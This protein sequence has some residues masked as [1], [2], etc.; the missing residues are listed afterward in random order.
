MFPAESYPN[1][2]PLEK[3]FWIISKKNP[4]SLLNSSFQ[5]QWAGGGGNFFLELLLPFECCS[6]RGHDIRIYTVRIK[7]SASLWAARRSF[8]RVRVPLNFRTNFSCYVTRS[9]VF[10]PLFPFFFPFS[11]CFYGSNAFSFVFSGIFLKSYEIITFRK[12]IARTF[13]RVIR[14]KKKREKRSRVVG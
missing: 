11:S 5:R 10:S 14:R 2:N 3:W 7:K 9:L 1:W 13:L 4:R 12:I 8:S 6:F